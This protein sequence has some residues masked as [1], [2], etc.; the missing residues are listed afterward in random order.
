MLLAKEQMDNDDIGT[1]YAVKMPMLNINFLIYHLTL[2]LF[3]QCENHG[4]LN[5]MRS[6][7]NYRAMIEVKVV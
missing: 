6:E 7:E 2:K 5:I 1:I 3:G 4:P